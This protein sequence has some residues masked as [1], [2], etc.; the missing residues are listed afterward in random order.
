MSR[1]HPTLRSRAVPIDSIAPWEDNP[2]LGDLASIRESLR[3]HG[4]YQPILVQKSTSTVIAGN[5]R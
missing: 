3:E 5:H 2:R 4:Q 1:I